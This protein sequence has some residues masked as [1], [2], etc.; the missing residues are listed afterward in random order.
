MA[1]SCA[2]LSQNDGLQR[3]ERGWRLAWTRAPA[4]IAWTARD[5]DVP[6]RPLTGR[7]RTRANLQGQ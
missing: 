1:I 4:L 2:K 5:N 7:R 6:R 3:V